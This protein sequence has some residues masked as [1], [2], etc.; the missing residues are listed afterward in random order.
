MMLSS[1]PRPTLADIVAARRRSVRDGSVAKLALTPAQG[2]FLSALRQNPL[3]IIAEIKPRSPVEGV[4]QTELDLARLLA[5]YD[6]HATA[7]SVLTEPNYFGGSFALLAAVTRRSKCPTLCKDFVLDV[8]QVHAARA[9]GAE[10]VLLIVKIL[11]DELLCQLHTEIQ[12][13]NMTP[14]V[15]VQ[16]EA[17]LERALALHPS[18]ILVNNR[19][20]ETFEVSLETTKR[21]APRVPS[22]I[23]TVSASGIQCRADIE[24]LLPYCSRFLIGT[25]LMRASDP[26]AIFAELLG[27]AHA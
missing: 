26:G 19:N 6:A 22:Q 20:L 25:H 14:V 4:L 16:T 3:A 18:V 13:W 17:E 9:A 15:E 24:A 5:A 10:A 1:A 21:L 2:R 23:V 7:L 12:R 11:A 27:Q 8:S